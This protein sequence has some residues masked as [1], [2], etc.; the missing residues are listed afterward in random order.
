MN[1][2]IGDGENPFSTKNKFEHMNGRFSVLAFNFP[3]LQLYMTWELLDY[4]IIF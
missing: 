3:D 1:M 4:F 2:A